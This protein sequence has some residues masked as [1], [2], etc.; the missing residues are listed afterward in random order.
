MWY[1]LEKKDN[2]YNIFNRIWRV[3]GG[4]RGA[5]VEPSP[6][7]SAYLAVERRAPSTIAIQPGE[8][9]RF[10]RPF[11]RYGSNPAATAVDTPDADLAD[12]TRAVPIAGRPAPSA[13]EAPTGQPCATALRRDP[14]AGGAVLENPAPTARQISHSDGTRTA[15][16]LTQ[17][18]RGRR[19]FPF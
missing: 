8:G 13:E 4:G 9:F 18:G 11:R 17:P 3:T 2:Y 6:R 12:P 5:G 7:K 1:V 16:Q 19:L 14:K 10:E 15:F